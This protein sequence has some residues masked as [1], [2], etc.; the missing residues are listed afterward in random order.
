[1]E[2]Q[3]QQVDCSILNDSI[4]NE[5]QIHLHLKGMDSDYKTDEDDVRVYDFI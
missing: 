5:D 1:M 2:T 3:L 4:D